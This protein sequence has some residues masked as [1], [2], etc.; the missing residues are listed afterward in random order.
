M[1]AVGIGTIAVP[2]LV[3]GKIMELLLKGVWYVPSLKQSL[4]SVHALAANGYELAFSDE[5]C[6]V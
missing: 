6:V 2:T 5:T 1:E 4:V 3:A